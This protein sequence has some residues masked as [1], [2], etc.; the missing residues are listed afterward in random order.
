MT[1]FYNIWKGLIN[2]L[3]HKIDWSSGSRT[4]SYLKFG[5]CVIIEPQEHTKKVFGNRVTLKRPKA[6]LP[7]STT[8]ESPFMRKKP[9]RV[10]AINVTQD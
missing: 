3:K 1:E 4:L 9:D 2:K 8:R 5:I 10:T 6:K 7:L